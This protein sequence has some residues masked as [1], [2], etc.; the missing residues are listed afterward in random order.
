MIKTIR[1]TQ[2]Y[3][4]PLVRLPILPQRNTI[5]DTE[6]NNINNIASFTYTRKELLSYTK[7][8]K[9]TLTSLL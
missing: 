9:N 8:Q 2:K 1:Q 7:K 4:V 6:Y 5:A 3:N